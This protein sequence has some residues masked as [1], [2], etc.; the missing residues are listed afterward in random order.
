MRYVSAILILLT[1]KRMIGFTRKREKWKNHEIAS[2]QLCA[3][4]FEHLKLGF[5]QQGNELFT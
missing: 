2:F 4:F 1:A 5:T 3:E